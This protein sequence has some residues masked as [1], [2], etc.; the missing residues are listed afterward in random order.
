MQDT[1]QRTSCDDFAFA[2]PTKGCRQTRRQLGFPLPHRLVAEDEATGQEHLRQIP[3]AQ[4][5]AQAPKHHEADDVTWVLRLVQHIG[6]ALVELAPHAQGAPR[7]DVD[8]QAG[9]RIPLSPGTI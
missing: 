5:L 3:Q 7:I 4:L 9:Q 6:A 8:L 2:L 1:T